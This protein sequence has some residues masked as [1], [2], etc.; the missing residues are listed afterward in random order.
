[1]A[2]TLGLGLAGVRFLGEPSR[3][4]C[5]WL[6]VLGALGMLAIPTMAFAIAGV[7][8]WLTVVLWRQRRA[9][10][11]VLRE[12]VVPCGLMT[13]GLTFVLYS[14]VI[15]RTGDLVRLIANPRVQASPWGHFAA[16]VGPHVWEVATALCRDIPPVVLLLGLVLL[17]VGLVGAWRRRHWPL[18]LLLPLVLVGAGVVLLAKR[19]LPYDRTWIYLIPLVLVMVDAGLA[20][21]VERLPG[22]LQAWA[23]A[24]LLTLGLL[25]AG[26]LMGTARIAT[27]DDTGNVPEVPALIRWLGPRLQPGDVVR[28]TG[29]AE[30]PTRYYLW[31]YGLPD[32]LGGAGKAGA[33]YFIVKKSECR[34]DQ[35]TRDPVAL[36]LDLDDAALYERQ[37]P[38]PA[39]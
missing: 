39:P 22:R 7:Y 21:L 35:L 11:P 23:A 3:V 37:R 31:Y 14:P 28:T 25:V 1:M 18:L 17:S 29:P 8:L 5:W 16:A 20:Y 10:A 30:S 36:L 26:W 12:F 27:Y 24:V 2:L 9:L 13:T 33:E 4:R 32:G 34:I 19:R 6:A 15:F 38:G